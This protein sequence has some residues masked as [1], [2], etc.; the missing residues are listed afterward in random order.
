[1]ADAAEQK[2]GGLQFSLMSQREG[3]V[4]I[5]GNC[6]RMLLAE[7]VAIDLERPAVERDGVGVPA[8]VRQ[9]DAE[10]VVNQRRFQVVRSVQPGPDFERCVVFLFGLGK[11]LLMTQI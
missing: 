1:M 7:N 8:L 6:P 5:S 2:L 3:E 10:V 9:A 11:T 4:T